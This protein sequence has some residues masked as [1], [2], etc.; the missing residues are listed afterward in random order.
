MK[1]KYKFEVIPGDA[2]INEVYL[3]LQKSIRTFL[4][5][6]SVGTTVKGRIKI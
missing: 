4:N 6:K 1:N 3:H 5:S 2:S